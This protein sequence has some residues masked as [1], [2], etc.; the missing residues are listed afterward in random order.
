LSI[1]AGFPDGVVLMKILDFLKR[2]KGSKKPPLPPIRTIRQ[3]GEARAKNQARLAKEFEES[4]A[5]EAQKKR[6]DAFMDTGPLELQGEFGEVDDPYETHSWE[7]E[8][9][10]GLRRIE[11]Q[12]LVNRKQPQGTP[13][14]P[15]DT[16]V[17]KK[18]W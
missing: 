4:G 17:K 3:P 16:I 11:D 8:Q 14:N 12:N 13:D 18:G 5:F 9:D 15:Y 6:E 2:D 1:Q 10:E 7:M